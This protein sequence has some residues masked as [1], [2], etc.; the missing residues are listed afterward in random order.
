M[1]MLLSSVELAD[2]L[3]L[4]LADE[5]TL[6]VLPRGSVETD[7]N[8]ALKAALALREATGCRAGA[9]IELHKRIPVGAGMGGGSADAAGVLRGLCA[10][11][12]LNLSEEQLLA[13]GLRLGADVP[14]QLTGGTQRVQGIGEVLRPVPRGLSP[15]LVGVQPCAGL[16]TKEIFTAFDRQEHPEGR[17]DN[18]AAEN[19]LRRGDLPMLCQ[20]MGNVM[21]PVSLLRE[22]EMASALKLLERLGALR[23]MMTGSGSVVYGVFADESIAKTARDSLRERWNTVFLTRPADAGVVIQRS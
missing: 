13:L 4:S 9:H 14:F 18:D 1:D 15:W 8:L 12:Q 20:A 7:N 17:P 10:L 22:P 3:T 16:S 11:W 19:A 21:Q 6:S 2:E 23:A 5:L